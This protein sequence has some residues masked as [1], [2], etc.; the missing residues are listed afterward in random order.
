M[1]RHGSQLW[2]LWLFGLLAAPVG[3]W[4]WQGQ[5]RNFGLGVAGGDVNRVVT[6]STLAVVF[7]MFVAM[8][9]AGGK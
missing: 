2:Q 5:G 3:V 9:I 8:L 4:L 6:Y 7:V 1:L